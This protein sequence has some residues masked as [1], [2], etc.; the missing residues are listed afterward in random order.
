MEVITKLINTDQ[1]GYIKG[2]YISQNFK[3]PGL[4][5]LIDFEKAFDTV[6]SD[7]LFAALKQFNLDPKFITWIK[8]LCQNVFLYQEGLDRVA[9]FRHYYLYW[10]QTCCQLS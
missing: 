1:V 7:F 2:R 6:E 10:L 5:G 4:I 8:L 3:I 9:Q